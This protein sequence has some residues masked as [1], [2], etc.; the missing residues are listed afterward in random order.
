M[1]GQMI[2]NKDRTAMCTDCTSFDNFRFGIIAFS[3]KK[4]NWIEISAV[5]MNIFIFKSF[6][7]K[8]ML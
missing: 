5:K 6:S 7:V 2:K 4:R 8:K 3:L 1:T